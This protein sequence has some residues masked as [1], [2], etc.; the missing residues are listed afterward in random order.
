MTGVAIYVIQVPPAPFVHYVLFMLVPV[1]ALCACSLGAFLHATAE[2]RLPSWTVPAALIAVTC[3]SLVP[4]V[5]HVIDSG[6]PFGRDILMPGVPSEPNVAELRAKIKAGQRVAM[7]GWTPQYLV[8]TGAVMGTRDSI[9]QFQIDVRPFRD[10]YRA[11]YLADFEANH[12]EFLLEAVGPQAYDY[13]DRTTQG[14]ASFPLLAGL[15]ARNYTLVLDEPNV[16]LFERN[17]L[18]MKRRDA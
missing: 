2:S 18:V 6:P 17:D 10:A 13:H 11:R 1:S 4:T 3:V 16:R 8:Y 7:W 14:I 15:I 5:H 12:P 9:S